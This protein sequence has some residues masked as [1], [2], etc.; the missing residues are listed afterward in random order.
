MRVN[1]GGGESSCGGEEG[2]VCMVGCGMRDRKILPAA[3]LVAG[4]GRS[5][6][7]S[8]VG[9]TACLGCVRQYYRGVSTE[10][11]RTSGSVSQPD[12]PAVICEA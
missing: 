7:I 4:S 2:T 9:V 6:V 1:R 11:V 8:V 10:L 12:W 5:V 3:V